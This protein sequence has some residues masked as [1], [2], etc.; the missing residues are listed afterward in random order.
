[1]SPQ[2]AAGDFRPRP[3]ADRYHRQ[4]LIPWWDQRRLAEARALVVGAGALGNEILKALALMGVGRVLI[5]DLDEVELSNLSRAVLFRDGDVGAP[6][7][8]VAARRMAELN[9]E[10][11]A[12]GR[13]ENVLYRAGLGVFRWADVVICG[14]DNRE[15]RLFVNAACARLGRPWVDGGIE[16]LSGVVRVFD[17]AAGACYECTM[18]E[19]DRRLVAERRSCAMLARRIVEA[20]QVPSTAVAASVV[21]ALQAAEALHLLHGRSELAGE[22]LFMNGHEFSRVRFPRR[23]DCYG[24]DSWGEVEPLGAGVADLTVGELVERAERELGEGATV[25]FSRDLVLEL[26]CPDCGA[27]EP[28]RAVLGEVGEERARCPGCGGHRLLEI[29]SSAYRGGPVDLAATPGALGLPPFDVV[30]ARQGLDR[31]RAWLFDAD[32]PAVLGPL[33][34]GEE[35]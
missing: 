27:A 31:R 17:P 8:T 13:A 5:Y 9:P 34:G 2:I 3:A 15:A 11:R 33:A 22:G 21:G 4:T 19:T 7:A 16:G 12:A 10:V 20:G 24:H 32:G 1:M 18:N 26:R 28:G 23:E 6:K 25:D 30:L 14:V 35:P 29:A